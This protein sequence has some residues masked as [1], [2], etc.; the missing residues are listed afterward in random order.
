M[1]EIT[2]E[3]SRTS[4]ISERNIYQ[5]DGILEKKKY[6][7]AILRGDDVPYSLGNPMY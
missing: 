5:K 2:N 7:S 4:G 3:N 1:G 6:L